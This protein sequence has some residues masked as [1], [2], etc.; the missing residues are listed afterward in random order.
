MAPDMAPDMGRGMGRVR[1]IEIAVYKKNGVPHSFLMVLQSSN[2]LKV[3][4]SIPLVFIGATPRTIRP[5]RTKII[6]YYALQHH[7]LIDFYDI[8]TLMRSM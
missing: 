6:E 4:G 8:M 3:K 7:F 2:H 5:F 1:S